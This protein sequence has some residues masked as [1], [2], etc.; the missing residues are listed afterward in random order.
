MP[1]IHCARQ[2]HG[3]T[4]NSLGLTSVSGNCEKVLKI[5]LIESPDSRAKGKWAGWARQHHS[6]RDLPFVPSKR[7][8]DWASLELSPS[9]ESC[10]CGLGA[11]C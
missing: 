4:Q 1:L 6:Q 10:G 9:V 2:S 8:P 5:V 7:L 11:T 3:R